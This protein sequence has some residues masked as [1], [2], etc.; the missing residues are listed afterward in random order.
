MDLK[1]KD[2]IAFVTQ[3]LRQLRQSVAA[4]VQPL[5]LRELTQRFQQRLDFQ[6]IATQFTRQ[7]EL[8]RPRPPRTFNR[9]F[10]LSITVVPSHS[11]YLFYHRRRS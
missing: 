4:E 6:R 5:Q 2:K 7:I 11:R 10:R 8:T 1:L 9:T 3:T